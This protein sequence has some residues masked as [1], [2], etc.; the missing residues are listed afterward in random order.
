[1]NKKEFYQIMK[2]VPKAEIHIHTEAVISRNTVKK[3]F[4]KSTGKTMSSEEMKD[5][6][7]YEDLPGFIAAFLK[8]QSFFTELSD[9]DLVFDDFQDYL[10]E[11]NIVYCEAFFSPSAFLKKG[12]SFHDMSQMISRNVKKIFDNTGRTLKILI[13]VSRTFGEENAFNNLNMILEEKNKNIIGIGLG[14]DESKGP[15]RDYK[16]VY[17]KAKE[18]KLHTVVHAGEVEESWS[19]KDALDLLGAERI[20]HGI[21][22]AYDP[23]LIER[24]AKKKIP[25]EVCPTSNTFTKK[26]VTEM[27]NHPIKELYQKGVMVTLN[28]DD[29]TFF[30]ASL[31]DEY[32]NLYSKLKFSMADICKIV[33]NGFNASFMSCAKKKEWCIKVDEILK[34]P[35]TSC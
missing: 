26:Y 27:K 8:I 12:F 20:G 3:L 9:F 15:A 7:S 30:K 19:I 6:F 22:A 29:P 28:T 5:L 31:L 2:Q 10:E 17:A 21:T 24:L 25:L 34:A 33:K 16:N 4:K 14:G 32:Y 1:M 35:C 13:D 18:S 23:E 11:N